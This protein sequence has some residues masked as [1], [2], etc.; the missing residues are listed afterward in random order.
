V[1]GE[2]YKAIETFQE[3]EESY[4]RDYVAPTNLGS[5]YSTQGQYGPSADQT[6]KAILLNPDNVYDYD[7]LTESLLALDRYDAARKTYDDAIARKLDDDA[8]HL[9]RYGLAFLQ[10]DQ[11]ELSD[12]TAWFE[13]RPDVEHEML[14]LEAETESYAGHLKK[15][16]ELRARAVDSAM[17]SDN[18]SAAAVWELSG[19]FNDELVGEPTAREKAIAAISRAPQSPDAQALGALVLAR[20]RE[21][22]RAESLMQDLQKRFPSHTILQSYWLPLIRAQIAMANKQPLEAVDQLQAAL[23]VEFGQPLSTPG[24]VCLFPVYVRGEAYLAAGQGSAAAAEFQ[25]LLDHRGITWSCATGALAR[26]GLARANALEATT[27][28]GSD[29]D[30]ARVRALTSYKDFLSLWKDADPDIPILKQSKAEY[31]KLK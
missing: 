3:W 11:K 30:A 7:N 9:A 27:M 31:A 15:A 24:P 14:A 25:K 17:R 12:Q 23:P 19:T 29:A 4:P 20:S 22:R 28:Q 26:L 8:L 16:R 18:K 2:S 13:H 1:S 6:Q 5:F 21:Y 10:S